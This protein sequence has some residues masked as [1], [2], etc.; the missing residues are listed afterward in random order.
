MSDGTDSWQSSLQEIRRAQQDAE[1]MRDQ[2]QAELNRLEEEEK[3][4]LIPDPLSHQK[5][6]EALRKA[7]LATSRAVE[8]MAQAL[9]EMERVQD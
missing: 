9:K 4:Y 3:T 5:G 2:L 1:R 7:I 6:M 8:S